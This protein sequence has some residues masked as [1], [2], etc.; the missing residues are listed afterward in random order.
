MDGGDETSGTHF[1]GVCSH[2][3]HSLTW[4]MVMWSPHNRWRDCYQPAAVLGPAHHGQELWTLILFLA[5][6]NSQLHLFQDWFNGNGA[7]QTKGYNCTQVE[8]TH[9]SVE[10]LESYFS[11]DMIRTQ[12]LAS[13]GEKDPLLPPMGTPFPPITANKNFPENKK[14]LCSIVHRNVNV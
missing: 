3:P 10:V 6:L 14:E 13:N 11:Q 9:P 5:L 12:P 2:A 8:I 1:L 7:V 4:L